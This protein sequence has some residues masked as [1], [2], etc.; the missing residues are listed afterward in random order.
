[1]DMKLSEEQ[2]QLKD[3]ARK[4]M[5]DEC[6]AD[7]IREMEASELGYSRE[8]WSQMAELGWLG[9]GLPCRQHRRGA[10]K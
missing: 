6:T 9:I 2:T 4:Y 3:A 1:M 5:E 8:M 7:F 10:H